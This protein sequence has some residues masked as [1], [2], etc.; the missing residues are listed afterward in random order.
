MVLEQCIPMLM[1]VGD[2]DEKLYKSTYFN[3]SETAPKAKKIF[4]NN[5][6]WLILSQEGNIYRWGYDWSGF[7]G[8]GDRYFNYSKINNKLNPQVVSVQNGGVS[9]KFKDISYLLTIGHRKIG[10]L[11]NTGE[12][13][14]WG[15]E[16]YNSDN[17]CTVTW[18]KKSMNI[19]APLKLTS[20]TSNLTTN[21]SFESIQGGLDAFVA[22]DQNGKY[23]KISQPYGKKIQVISIDDSIKSYSSY[24]A[25]DDAEL[26]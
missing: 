5:Q 24:K 3:G 19:C 4:S 9:E 11:S 18:E 20:E 6:I 21:K 1:L 13:Y 22:K 2:N 15:M 14:I 8:N 26:L 17:D 7:S 16:S 23:F 25:T 12:F 10:A